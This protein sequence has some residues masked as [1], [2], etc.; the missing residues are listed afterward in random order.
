MFDIKKYLCV[1][2]GMGSKSPSTWTWQPSPTGM[3][4]CF[5]ENRSE[6]KISEIVPDSGKLISSSEKRGR[7]VNFGN[8]SFP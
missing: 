1:C 3:G 2:V 8:A 5:G 6:K 7:Q 4:F